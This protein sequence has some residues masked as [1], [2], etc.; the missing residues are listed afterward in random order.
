[1]WSS[2]SVI[3][4]HKKW[5]SVKDVFFKRLCQLYYIFSRRLTV[6]KGYGF[7]STSRRLCVNQLLK[8]TWNSIQDYGIDGWC[9]S[10]KLQSDR[11]STSWGRQGCVSSLSCLF[12][13]WTQKWLKGKLELQV[14]YKTKKSYSDI[15]KFDH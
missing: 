15:Y 5:S 12:F 13:H 8:K 10:N 11:S 7:W 4:F 6:F 3:F 14:R 1:M 9:I 2:R